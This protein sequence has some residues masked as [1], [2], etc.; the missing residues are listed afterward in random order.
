MIR[1]KLKTKLVVLLIIISCILYS[2]QIQ[3]GIRLVCD[4]WKPYQFSEQGVVL[5]YSYDIVIHVMRELDTD[6]NSMDMLPWKRAVEMLK[7]DKTDALF[8]ANYTHERA[9]YAYYPDEPLII[10][11]WAIWTNADSTDEYTNLGDL[12]GKAVGIVRGYSYT[13]EFISFISKYCLVEETTYDKQNF[14]KLEDGRL[15]YIIAEYGNGSALLNELGFSNIVPWLKNP[16]KTD[17][18]Y[19]IFNKR[20]VSHEFTEHFSHITREFKKTKEYQD[21][22]RKYF[23][24]SYKSIDV[25]QAQR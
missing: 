19:I 24:D 2:Q 5:G 13:E 23:G 8:S 22:L 9:A 21:L 16:V 11:P 17:G 3:K 18:L 12:K 1:F 7:N 25:K 20:K 6:I 10:S 14:M 15:D 4:D